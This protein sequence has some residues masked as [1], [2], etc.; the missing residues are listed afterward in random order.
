MAGTVRNLGYVRTSNGPDLASVPVNN[1]RVSHIGPNSPSKGNS[2]AQQFIAYSVSGW[3]GRY[4]VGNACVIRYG[5]WT[6]SSSSAAPGALLAQSEEI[7]PTANYVDAAGGQL[8]TGNLVTPIIINV[9]DIVAIGLGSKTY[10]AGVAMYQAGDIT[11]SNESFYT[12]TIT[13][14]TLQTAASSTVSTE[15]QLAL[16]INGEYNVKPNQPGSATITAGGGTLQPTLKNT[17]SDPNETLN[18]GAAFDRLESIRM[19]V[20]WGGIRRSN[21]QWTGTT[22]ER[23][24]R[25]S[26][27]QVP[28][29][30][31]YDTAITVNVFHI[32]RGGMESIARAYTFTVPSPSTGAVAQPTAPSGFVTNL[33]NPGTISAV[34]TNTGGLAA[35][36]VR[37]Q[38]Q[39][40]NGNVLVTSAI[41]TKSVAVGATFTST[42][43]ASTLGALDAGAVYQ[44]AVQA[45]DTGGNWTPYSPV[46]NLIADA[47][48]STPSLYGPPSGQIRG[49]VPELSVRFS[50]PD[51]ASGYQLQSA[52]T[53]TA[54]ILNSGGTEIGTV[55][56]TYQA[57]N[58]VTNLFTAA[59][60]VVDDVVTAY[61][62]YSWYVVASDGALTTTSSTWNFTYAA[63]PVVTITTP[64]G[65]NISTSAPNFVWT[66][67]TQ[68]KY[69]LYAVNGGG[70]RV[71]DTGEVVTGTKNHTLTLGNWIGGE[72]WNNLETFTWYVEVYDGTLWGSS[73]GKTLTL[74][75][76]PPDPVD[77]Q[78]AEAKAFTDIEGTHY[79]QM[80]IG[81]PTVPLGSFLETVVSRVEITGSG[82]LEVAGTYK[83]RYMIGKSLSD[84]LYQDFDVTSNTWYRYGFTIRAIVSG[85]T[86]DSV[87]VYADMMVSWWGVIV[88]VVTN[89]LDAYV[90][91][92]Y[93]DDRYEVERWDEATDSSVHP[94]NSRYPI[95]F[96]GRNHTG[97]MSGAFTIIS[98]DP[99]VTSTRLLDDFWAVYDYQFPDTSPDGRPHTLCAREGRGGRYGRMYGR[100]LS[101]HVTTSPVLQD[102]RVRF[103]F[104]RTGNQEAG[105]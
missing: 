70:T 19:E 55:A 63:V 77:L 54:H 44:Y 97:G 52:L 38:L 57:G 85:D 7:T 88:H 51:V 74:S 58:A 56:L 10:P 46:A 15:G 102:E 18:S 23:N 66:V 22:T 84:T 6:A 60:T 65:P 12:K 79:V 16:A 104:T 92:R 81:A 68:T 98:E 76:T 29:A 93:G 67:T 30:G 73:A 41:I 48:P 42:W 14:N 3:V 86:V 53:A 49:T 75:Y 80:M 36:A 62:A 71:Y 91:L 40:E 24:G 45:R 72:R 39:D 27:R 17:F 43:A 11:Q 103:T 105:G 50:D 83:E 90:W 13:G 21:T 5:I 9:G 94:V 25:Y 61:G 47:A 8:L 78:S 59:S 99:E 95:A 100:M 20:W 32:D 31:P 34:Y 87:P 96:S 33:A 4:S 69:R 37:Y 26:E 35:N 28:T 64:A 89:P 101:P 1:Q 82:G 2:P